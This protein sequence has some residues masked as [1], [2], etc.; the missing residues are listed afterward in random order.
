MFQKSSCNCCLIYLFS[1]SS[2]FLFV[3]VF[4][5]LLH[6]GSLSRRAS[7]GK[8]GV[9][10]RTHVTRC[11]HVTLCTPVTRRTHVTRCTHATRWSPFT[12]RKQSVVLLRS[13]IVYSTVAGLFAVCVCVCVCVCVWVWV[14]V[15]VCVCVWWLL[16]PPP[17][18][19][20]FLVFAKG[21]YNYVQRVTSPICRWSDQQTK[22][23]QT[24]N[25][26]STDIF[27]FLFV[28]SNDWFLCHFYLFLNL[29]LVLL[30]SFSLF[31]CC[32]SCVSCYYALIALACC[33][34]QSWPCTWPRTR[35][36]VSWDRWESSRPCR[37]STTAARG[38]GPSVTPLAPYGGRGGGGRGGGCLCF[39]AFTSTDFLFRC[40]HS[41]L[42][43]WRKI[44]KE[45]M[46]W[47]PFST[48]ITN[49]LAEF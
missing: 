47:R 31:D 23:Q 35:W 42:V 18:P 5:F 13:C 7:P 12:F 20:P 29:F 22:R 44:E 16:S 17:P 21:Q 15:C 37:P 9:T 3:L 10:R 8:R 19:P 40:R 45:E 36:G 14:C 43:R 1:S 34:V 38:A 33:C 24:K 26:S 27:S 6:V 39:C 49:K 25:N 11:T 48:H 46:F 28:A 4:L 30:V 32:L 41:V 2:S